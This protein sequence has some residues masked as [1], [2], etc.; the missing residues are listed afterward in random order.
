MRM[1]SVLLLAAFAANCV[2]ADEAVTT[3]RFPDADTVV[4]NDLTRVAYN[5]DGTYA[6]ESETWQKILTEKGRREA[7][8]ITVSYSKRYAEASIDFVRVIDTNG[9]E[10]TIDVSATTK[11][12]TDNGSM[13]SNIYDPLDRDIV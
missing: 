10:R 7:S 9:V 6:L 1:F 3:E 11:E 12:M 5:P 13:A 4:V 2:F 8:S